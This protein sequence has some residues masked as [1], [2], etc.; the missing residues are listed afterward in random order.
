M[1]RL[2]MREKWSS[3]HFY[4]N[5]I[6][7]TESDFLQDSSDTTI[8]STSPSTVIYSL[9][10]TLSYSQKVTLALVE[11][12]LYPARASI[13]LLNLPETRRKEKERLEHVV[14]LAKSA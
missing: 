13:V 6:T 11:C 1:S 7:L 5:W 2:N 3:E 12:K 10:R 14:V 8:V 4:A 9:S